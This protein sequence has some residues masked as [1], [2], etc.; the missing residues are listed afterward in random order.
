M[1]P[2][3]PI[4]LISVALPQIYTVDGARAIGFSARASAETVSSHL[5]G[6][7]RLR[8]PNLAASTF[9]S[10]FWFFG[11]M[12]QPKAKH[13]ACRY[14][15]KTFNRTEH[16]QRHE[17]IRTTVRAYPTTMLTMNAIKIRRRSHLV[18]PVAKPLRAG[19]SRSGLLANRMSLQLT[20]I[21][22]D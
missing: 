5:V 19:R 17:R 21:G 1:V 12:T 22:S 13:L 20:Q 3:S 8:S 4:S 15:R 7:Y 11:D 6:A 14:C 16:L 9:Y 10:E 2:S 18:V